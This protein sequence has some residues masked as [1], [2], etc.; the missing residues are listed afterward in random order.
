MS[1]T[2]D[3]VAHIPAVAWRADRARE[4]DAFTV[5]FVTGAALSLLGYPADAWCS[6][7]EFWIGITHANDRDLALRQMRDVLHSRAHAPAVVRWMHADG[8]AVPMEVHLVKVSG[9]NGQADGL[10]GFALE[11]SRW[12]RV[13]E[14]LVRTRDQLAYASRR[15]TLNQLV[16]SLV[17]ELNQPLNAILNNAEAARI[18]LDGA[19]VRESEIAAMLDEIIAANERAGNIIRRARGLAREGD[20]ERKPVDLNA[21]VLDVRELLASEALLR[22]AAIRTRLAPAPCL[23]A[24]DFVQLVQVLLNLAG[25]ALD[26]VSGVAAKERSVEVEVVAPP[27]DWVAIAVVDTGHGIPP[28][29]LQSVFEPLI[30]TKIEGLGLGLDVASSIVRSH[31]GTM[32]AGNNREGG[33]HFV[34]ALPRAR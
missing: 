30:S 2:D 26:A 12:A 21:V 18:V 3:P 9:E 4:G 22:S 16:A 5:R 28:D 27:G 24:G 29:M 17:H 15:A 11:V 25:N 1:F 19:G 31:G 6:A 32:W 23:V 34:L 10:R 14:D 13:Q 8:G 33:A 20:T 7:P